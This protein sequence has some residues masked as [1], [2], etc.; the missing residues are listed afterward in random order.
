M[1]NSVKEVEFQ[2]FCPSCKYFDYGENEYPCEV[3]LEVK[4]RYGTFVP[5][6]FEKGLKKGK[7]S[8]KNQP[9]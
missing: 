3:C 7:R 2:R 8:Q 9:L 1:D 5:E 6:K 4:A